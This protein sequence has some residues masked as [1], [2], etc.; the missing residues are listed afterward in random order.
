M[1]FYS[2]LYVHLHKFII[3]LVDDQRVFLVWCYYDRKSTVAHL[4]T[5]CGQQCDQVPDEG[6]EHDEVNITFPS[7]VWILPN[8][9]RYHTS[10]SCDALR[11]TT[12]SLNGN[13]QLL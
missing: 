5:L 9:K 10:S 13:P 7:E 4:R 6:T 12:P 2:L 1:S 11:L 8:G 3:C